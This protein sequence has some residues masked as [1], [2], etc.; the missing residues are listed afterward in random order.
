M[1]I[2]NAE[3]LNKRRP[4]IESLRTLSAKQV[5]VFGFEPLKVSSD[6]QAVEQQIEKASRFSFIMRAYG[7]VLATGILG[8]LAWVLVGKTQV[9]IEGATLVF[10]LVAAILIFAMT[11]SDPQFLLRLIEKFVT[12]KKEPER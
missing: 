9:G 6:R 5:G 12:K 10:V 8:Y 3:V 7:T 2:V 1:T 4:F 11:A